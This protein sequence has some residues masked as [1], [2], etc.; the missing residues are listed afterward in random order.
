MS[1]KFY[2][3]W[4][5]LDGDVQRV[6]FDVAEA[7]DH[8]TNFPLLKAELDKWLAGADVDGGFMESL[9]ADEGQPTNPTAID[10]VQAIAEMQDTV[11]GRSYKL[12][13]PMPNLIKVD[14]GETP[15]NPAFINQ[16]GLRVFN[17]DH[18]D[19]ALLVAQ[20]ENT[21]VTP[22]GNFAQCVRIYIEE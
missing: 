2:F 20:L 12:R 13:L 14:D 3:A 4:R 21:Y 18:T 17:S 1:D 9:V 19:Y 11:T 5:D 10:A 8:A 16:G 15:P 22:A 6:S 7:G